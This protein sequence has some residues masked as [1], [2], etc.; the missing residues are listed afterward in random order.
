M[1]QFDEQLKQRLV[2]FQKAHGL[3]DTGVAGSETW[4]RLAET[5][6]AGAVQAQLVGQVVPTVPPGGGPMLPVEPG[7]LPNIPNSGFGA[8]FRAA[9]A[10]GEVMAGETALGEGAFAAA[11]ADVVLA[12]GTATVA[13]GSVVV[14][15]TAVAE[16]TVVTGG[17]VITG[18]AAA[19]GAALTVIGAVVVLG[20]VYF[21][22]EAM[23]HTAT[24]P[25]PGQEYPGTSLPGG[26]PPAIAPGSEPPVPGHAPGAAEPPASLP[27]SEPPGNVRTPG[28]SHEPA[29]APGV[30]DDPEVCLKLIKAGVT[31]DHHIFPREFIHEFE[32]I[33]INIDEFTVTLKAAEHI[34]KNG[35]HSTMDWNYEWVEFFANFPQASLTEAQASRWH[36]KAKAKAAELMGD[37]GID[38][39]TMHWYRKPN[40]ISGNT[41]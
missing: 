17:T 26:A 7:P 37:A 15:G 28:A 25:G 4:T 22:V 6:T 38:T 41:D 11:E 9:S 13:E 31:H 21:V 20:T 29:E 39:K 18:G 24:T 16:G 30:V 23:S 12:G 2:A 27:G 35:I 3:D 10:S 36:Q 40:K 32:S 14:G 19:A 8:G 1:T 34:G 33:G 5:A